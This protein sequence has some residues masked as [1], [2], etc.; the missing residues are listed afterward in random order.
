MAIW[1]IHNRTLEV[2][3]SLQDLTPGAFDFEGHVPIHGSALPIAAGKK[4]LVT[5][6]KR[7][8][9]ISLEWI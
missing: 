9:R 2:E 8:D 6:L 3:H 4:F 1:H 7:S 5:L